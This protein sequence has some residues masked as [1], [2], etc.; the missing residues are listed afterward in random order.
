M[1]CREPDGLGYLTFACPNHPAEIRHV[2][3]SCKSRF[4]SVCAKVQVDNWVAKMNELFPNCPYFH[5]TFTVPS[6]FRQLLFSKRFLINAV[7]K[8]ATE[9]LLSFCKEQGFLPAI[10]VVLHTFGS[11][12]KQHIHVHLIISAGGLKLLGK[13]E[14]YRRFTVR[15]QKHPDAKQ[16]I[17]PV[18]TKNTAWISWNKFP[19]KVL[20]KRYQALLIKHLKALVLENIQ[21]KKPDKDLEVFKNAQA[22]Y[23]FFDQVKK[24][25][26]DGFYVHI[27]KERKE[28]KETIGYIGRY[29]RRP[30]ISEVRLKEYN[31]DKVTF[32]YKDYYDNGSKVRWTLD[33]M[34]FIELLIQHIPPHYFNVIRHYG[35]VASRVKS[36]YKVITDRFLG[37]LN[38]VKKAKSWAQRQQEYTGKNPLVCRICKTV[39]KKV[40]QYSPYRLSEIRMMFE[41]AFPSG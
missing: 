30:P 32:E 5:A 3:K 27:S 16:R 14:R 40:D 26:R 9:T 39:M 37:H 2:P 25:Y 38:G 1:N 35:I 28:L 6:Q 24:D 10:T 15:K 7:F 33:V 31:G 8:A 34:K 13:Q 22:L 19:Y 29:A 18:D 11:D 21:S 36:V 23:N 4:C 12:L 41:K 20:H 17:Y